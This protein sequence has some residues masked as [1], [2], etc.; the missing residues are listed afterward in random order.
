[1]YQRFVLILITII[2]SSSARSSEESRHF[3]P[4][5]LFPRASPTRYQFISGIGIPLGTPESI[6]SGWVMKA[7]YFLPAS[8]DDLKPTYLEGWN[9]SR[10]SFEK[11]EATNVTPLEHYE[12]YQADDVKIE[13][14]PL[15]EEDDD[16][17]EDADD[18]YQSKL[19]E[20][21]I[22]QSSNLG[23]DFEN[24]GYNTEQSRWTT[25]KAL[26]QIGAIY[27][28]GGRECVL[29]SICE[30]ASA[31]FTHTG[32]VFAELLHIIFTPSTTTEVLSDHNDNE[33]YR[34]ELIGKDGAPCHLVF[35]E[36]RFSILDIFTGVHD[37]KTNSLTVKHDKLMLRPL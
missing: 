29:R 21:S 17:F 16:Q 33:Y 8:I 37:T 25:Y 5:L 3:A 34:A 15:A 35:P 1:M 2:N 26:E 11:R 18:D 12:T 32:G 19:E 24:E 13:T 10:R 30:A 20:D 31:E 28:A 4:L 27:G 22:Q 14:E 6:I 9:D 23:E 36:C 7:Q